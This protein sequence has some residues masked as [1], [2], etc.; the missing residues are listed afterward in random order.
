[1]PTTAEPSTTHGSTQDRLL[2]AMLGRYTLGLS[3][4][5]L[6][7]A[8]EDWLT[9]LALAP[10]K[11]QELVDK[12]LRKLHRFVLYAAHAAHA[13]RGPCPAC[14]E[15]LP[16]DTRFAHAHWQRWPFNLVYQAFLFNQ[17]WWYNA[18]TEVHGV[19]P[20]HEQVVTFVMRQ[21]L[22]MMAPSN[23][24]A[25]NPE[26]LAQTARTGGMNLLQG[27]Q[28]WWNDAERLAAGR[29][30]E[31]VEAYT[32]GRDVAV[33]P[34]KVVYRNR[35]IELIQYSPAHASAAKSVHPEPLLIVPSWIMKYYILDLSPGNSLVRY[36]VA[37]GHTVF[38]ISWKN[39]DQN[40]RGLGM[41][42]YLKMGVMDAIEAVSAVTQARG[43][44]GVGYCLGGTLLAIAAAAMAR[45]HD[46]RLKTL[47]LLA[48][49]LDFKDP[50]ELSLFMDESQVAWL[51]DIMWDRGYLDGQQMAGAFTLLNSKDLVWSRMVRDYL[52]G[53]RRPLNDLMAWNADATR[54]PS[55]MHSEYLRR[56]YL[57][58]DLAEGRY[59][60][61][62]RPI[63]LSDIRVPVFAVATQ[64]D[65]VSPWRSVYKI[66]LLTDTEVTFL[67]ASGG[68]NAGIVSEPGH[69][70]RSYQ[71]AR[72]TGN[73]RYL[74]PE[75]WVA[76]TLVQEGSW[77]PEWQ[78]WL[79]SHSGKRAAPPAMGAPARG[80][81]VLADAPGAY[82]LAG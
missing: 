70:H 42:D 64:R 29:R 33:T 49:E 43:M 56:L 21:L 20:H 69:A 18:T 50:G 57:G 68:H 71:A 7:L 28:N 79:A 78:R 60:V 73:E 72:R 34:G 51:E 25:T 32:P 53:R 27:F 37:Q 22:D 9:H 76:A 52:M 80:Y 45:E 62:G 14:I 26:V 61:D 3:P 44:H 65:H 35:L 1:M 16:Q 2:H 48:S 46:T 58:N 8:F 63:A 59:K 12:A 23:F 5:A 54:L 41:H 17:Q 6:A 75:A 31:G 15:P 74:D 67:L 36:L 38:M 24:V 19:S 40:D 81:A 77:W 11:Q 47:T 13:A 39:P 10:G 4:A 66:H 30:P 55:R 82:V